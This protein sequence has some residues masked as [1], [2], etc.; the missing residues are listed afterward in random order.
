M[1]VATTP[2]LRCMDGHFSKPF[3]APMCR[4][5]RVP[6][7]ENILC[8]SVINLDKPTSEPSQ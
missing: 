2:K 4:L 5:A 6:R 8:F 7:K 3:I 1:Y